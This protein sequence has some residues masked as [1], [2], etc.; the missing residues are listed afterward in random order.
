VDFPGI[1]SLGGHRGSFW[2]AL[3]NTRLQDITGDSGKQRATYHISFMTVS[4]KQHCPHSDIEY[5]LDRW[6]ESHWYI[7][8]MEDNYHT[9]DLF[10]YCVNSFIRSIREVPQLLSMELQNHANYKTTFKQII[11]SINQDGLLSLL[12][13]K[14]DFIVHRGMLE[15]SSEGMVGTTEGRGV[16]IGIPFRVH[17]N[18]AS[19]D[20]YE[21]FKNICR[22]DKFIRGLAGPDCDS[23]PCIVR[24]WRIQE[25]EGLDLLDLSVSAWRKVGGG[26]SELVKLLGGESLDLTLSCR[27]DPA[28]VRMIEFSQ[29]EFFKSVDG[30]DINK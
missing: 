21:R 14:R 3:G 20:A 8:Q 2:G 30:I 1:Y 10:R 18:E 11:Y 27:H 12:H 23:W 17:P 25:F 28:K 19:T 29:E 24:Y 15:L 6:V 5:A 16:K 4:P 13:K 22:Q 9:P 7:H 26:L